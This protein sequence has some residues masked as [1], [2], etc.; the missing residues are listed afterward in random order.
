ME[1]A[2]L[3]TVPLS[4]V[5]G[6]VVWLSLRRARCRHGRFGQSVSNRIGRP[7][8]IRIE[9]RSFAGPYSNVKANSTDARQIIWRVT[10]CTSL[11]IMFRATG[12]KQKYN[13]NC[14][15]IGG[16]RDVRLHV[17]RATNVEQ[18]YQ[19]C[20]SSSSRNTDTATGWAEIT[21]KQSDI[22]L[23]SF[24]SVLLWASSSRQVFW[25]STFHQRRTVLQIPLFKCHCL[26][27]Y[28]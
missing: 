24:A 22:I 18:N 4:A 11:Q 5:N 7:I 12:S 2:S 17:R 19:S 28:T 14:N 23:A 3:Y 21:C 15:T 1:L 8:R 6:L 10:A 16:K 27:I 25:Y 9:S 13:R 20:A 26:Y